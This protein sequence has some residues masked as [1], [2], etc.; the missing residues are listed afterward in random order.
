MKPVTNTWA[1]GGS[2]HWGITAIYAYGIIPL[3]TL[4]IS[5]ENRS[6][7]RCSMINQ[8]SLPRALGP[9]T[10]IV[11]GHIRFRSSL[12]S[13]AGPGT[14]RHALVNRPRPALQHTSRSPRS[15]GRS[16]SRRELSRETVRMVAEKIHVDAG[17][18]HGVR[19][20]SDEGSCDRRKKSRGCRGMPF[21]RPEPPRSRRGVVRSS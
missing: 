14:R 3:V 6:G 17:K 2:F 13:L 4:L 15:R 5:R 16:R 12:T 19:E 18:Y 9:V 7:L 1:K 10:M 20:R 8:P 11:I 21:N